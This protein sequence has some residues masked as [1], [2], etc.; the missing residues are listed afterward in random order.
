[1]HDVRERSKGCFTIWR[2][3]EHPEGRAA[4]GG[5]A[6]IVPM[7]APPGMWSSE[8]LSPDPIPP[9]SRSYRVGLRQVYL[10]LNSQPA[11]VCVA[12]MT[13]KSPCVP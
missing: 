9:P 1:M 3:E 4:R 5:G 2:V 12:C 7:V 11:T 10:G 8:R 6:T 13:K